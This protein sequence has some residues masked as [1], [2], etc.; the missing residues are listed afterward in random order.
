MPHVTDTIQEWVQRV[1]SQ[2]VEADKKADVCLIELGGTIGDIEGMPF[3]EAF[4]QFQFRVGRDNFTVVHVSLIPET[5]GGEQK[6]KPVQHSVRELRGMGLSPDIIMCR[7]KD[8]ISDGVKSKVSL[9]CHVPPEQA[10][11]TELHILGG[12]GGGEDSQLVK[13]QALVLLRVPEMKF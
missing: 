9:F 2:P 10:R 13:I 8:S 11:L 6:T 4:R 12:G 1:A 5:S 7:C 3:V